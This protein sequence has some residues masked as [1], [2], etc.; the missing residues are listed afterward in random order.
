MPIPSK[1]LP[2]LS[3]QKRFVSQVENARVIEYPCIFSYYEWLTDKRKHFAQA[4]DFFCRERSQASWLLPI[5][6]PSLSNFRR[7]CA[8]Q[9]ESNLANI[10][11]VHFSRIAVAAVPEVPTQ[12]SL[13]LGL[14]GVAGEQMII[15]RPCPSSHLSLS[16]SSVPFALYV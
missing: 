4:K 13:S 15:S 14:W 3:T 11:T 5:S 7:F 8:A 6:P 12:L 9:E 1:N 10:R 2:C 16:L